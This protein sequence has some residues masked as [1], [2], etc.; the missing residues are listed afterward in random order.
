MERINPMNPGAT[1]PSRGIVRVAIIGGGIAGLSA[2]YDLAR[3]G[4]YAVTVYEG[5]SYLGGLAAGFKGHSSWEWPLEHF[6]H[7]LFTN[8]DAIIGLTRELGLADLLEIHSPITAFHI[9]GKNYPLDTPLRVLQFPLL[10]PADRLRMGMVIAYL[11]YHPQR[12]WRQFDKIVAD[13][14]LARWM[15]EKAYQTLWQPMLQGKFG[16]HY[17]DVN[18]AWFW[19]RI[20]KRTPKLGYYRGGFQAFVDGL[21][22]ATERLGVAVQTSA[23][24]ERIRPNADG[25]LV[26]EVAGQASTS[27]DVVLSTV[28]PGLMRRLT[29]DLPSSY[30]GQ[31]GA[32]RSMGAVVTTVALKRQLMPKI[33]WANIPKKEGLPFLALVE[34]TNMIDPVHYGGDHLIYIGDYLDTDHRYFDL[35]VDELL[36]EF[37]PH[38]AKLNPEFRPDWITGA[39]V[40]KAKYAQPVPPVEYAEMIPSIRTPQPGLY[41]ASM[42]Q[43]YPWDRGTNYAVEIG[44]D[45]AKMISEDVGAGVVPVAAPIGDAAYAA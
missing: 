18:L 9:Q 12:P 25:G 13:E 4:G 21:A 16:A 28:G 20:Y 45:V 32:L 35:D 1:M 7:H 42:S 41:F 37:V 15:G 30:L 31:L 14:W 40:H 23:R 26:V 10:P 44:R 22:G 3:Q 17:R 43:V 27:Y 38:L 33:Y 2:A 24:V 36:A 11:R 29:P 8:D 6:Y 5:N 39:W 34:H 19:A